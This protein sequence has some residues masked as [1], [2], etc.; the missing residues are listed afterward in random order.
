MTTLDPGRALESL[1]VA[2]GLT[3]SLFA[4]RGI[5]RWLRLEAERKPRRQAAALEILRAHRGRAIGSY[6]LSRLV[7]NCVGGMM[8]AGTWL[9]LM[10]ELC[11]RGE[12][13]KVRRPRGPEQPGWFGYEAVL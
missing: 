5:R 9:S 8:G 12:V 1:A 2:L 11:A 3:S 4:V 6:E 10:D 13:R 7:E